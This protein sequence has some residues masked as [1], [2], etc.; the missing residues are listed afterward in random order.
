M[1]KVIFEFT[2]KNKKHSSLYY[3]SKTDSKNKPAKL[4]ITKDETDP[5]IF[6]V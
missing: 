3:K 6:F 2:L 4:M 1:S 5:F